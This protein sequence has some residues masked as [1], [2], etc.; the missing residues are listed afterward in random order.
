MW[1]LVFD[2][3]SSGVFNKFIL[4]AFYVSKWDLYISVIIFGNSIGVLTKTPL[5]DYCFA[6]P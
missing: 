4:S 1:M 2:L 3:N 5:N 6:T